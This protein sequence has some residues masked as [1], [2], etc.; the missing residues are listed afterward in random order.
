MWIPKRSSNGKGRM[1]K[2]WAALCYLLKDV[3]MQNKESRR[4]RADH[5]EQT[6]EGR[7][8]GISKSLSP[9]SF[10]LQI[11][12][13]YSPKCTKHITIYNLTCSAHFYALTMFCQH[14]TQRQRIKSENCS[15][16]WTLLLTGFVAQDGIWY[17]ETMHLCR[18]ENKQIYP[19]SIK[20]N[21]NTLWVLD[22]Y[23]YHYVCKIL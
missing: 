2:H 4:Q 11:R 10:L 22:C 12:C 8:R 18:M 9:R 14:K 3:W 23:C 7:V 5:W 13:C 1:I 15:L 17:T 19:Y 16:I 6:E 20:F 21:K